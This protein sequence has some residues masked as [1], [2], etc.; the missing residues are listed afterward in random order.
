MHGR[1]QAKQQADL[2]SEASCQDPALGN[3]RH[4]VAPSVHVRQ[5]P[6]LFAGLEMGLL[7]VPAEC[8][9]HAC[10]LPDQQVAGRS[11]CGQTHRSG[12]AS[13]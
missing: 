6:L 4:R 11:A 10:S 3:G 7:P 5:D 2:R 9:P 1:T 12:Y 13:T 8:V